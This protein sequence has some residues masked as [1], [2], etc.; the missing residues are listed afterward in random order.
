MFLVRRPASTLAW[1][2][3]GRVTIENPLPPTL[4]LGRSYRTRS[5]QRTTTHAG[6]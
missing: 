6:R 1:E 2:F 5:Q 4:T 3:H